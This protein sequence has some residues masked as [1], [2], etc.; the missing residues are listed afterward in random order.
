M[1]AGTIFDKTRTPLTV[2]FTAC[3]SFATAKDGISVLSLQRSLEIGSYQ[4]AWAMLARF[5]SVLVHPGRR[6]LNGTV[7]V[8]ETCIGGEEPGLAGWRA[9]SGQEGPD[10]CA[11]GRF[12]QNAIFREIVEGGLDPTEGDLTEGAEEVG[13]SHLPSGSGVILGGGASRHTAW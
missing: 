5:R 7:E 2:W 13:I 12:Q 1:T 10:R 4:T 3:W 6:R 9:C 11:V 8:D